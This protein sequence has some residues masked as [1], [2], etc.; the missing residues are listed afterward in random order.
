[1]RVP[2]ELPQQRVVGWGNIPPSAAA[3]PVEFT[4]RGLAGLSTEAVQKLEKLRPSTVGQAGR[5]SGITPAA[6]SILLVHL[7]RATA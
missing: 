2:L 3:I 4:Y 7:R 6:V 1:M 5:I